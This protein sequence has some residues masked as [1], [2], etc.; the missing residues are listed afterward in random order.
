MLDCS[1]AGI[2]EPGSSSA[3][4]VAFLGTSAIGFLGKL[5]SLS[6][7]SSPL[8]CTLLSPAAGFAAGSLGGAGLAASVFVLGGE[9][10]EA[11]SCDFSDWG[12]WSFLS[13]E[14]AAG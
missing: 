12:T 6:F 2:D 1:T 11:G 13:L 8:A 4:S 10:L 14:S 9:S 3:I 7:G 5:S